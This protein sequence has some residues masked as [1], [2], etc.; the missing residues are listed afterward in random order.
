M[1]LRLVL[2]DGPELEGFRQT[3]QLSHRLKTVPTAK[4]NCKSTYKRVEPRGSL[5]LWT[6]YIGYSFVVNRSLTLKG[7]QYPLPCHR[8]TP[9]P[10][11]CQ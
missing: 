3:T 11:L 8:C 10:L 1:R 7:L 6:F 9:D 4:L 5:R 2:Q